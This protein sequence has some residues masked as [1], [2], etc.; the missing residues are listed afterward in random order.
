MIRYLKIS[1]FL[2]LLQVNL[3]GQV[4]AD[5]SVL[6][7]GK[8]FRIAVTEDGI[9]RIDFSKLRQLGLENPSNPSIYGNNSGQL[10]YKNDAAKPDD[11]K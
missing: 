4:T 10:S 1:L 3:S 9:Y 5:M 6:S 11:L 8:W 2:F 7:K